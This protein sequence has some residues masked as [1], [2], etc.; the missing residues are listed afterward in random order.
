MDLGVA[1]RLAMTRGVDEFRDVIRAA[2]YEPPDN[3]VPGVFH[4]FPAIGK[5]HSNS[6]AW[7]KLFPDGAGGIY[8]DF[9]TG[10]SEQWQARRDRPMSLIER[11]GYREEIEKARAEAAAKRLQDQAAAAE[12]AAAL[13]KESAPA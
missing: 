13:W 4:R 3:L 5:R 6:S 10:F 7:A 1:R 12:T 8:G 2:G 9:S 11:E